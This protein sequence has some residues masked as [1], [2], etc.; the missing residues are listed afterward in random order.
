MYTFVRALAVEH[1][2][3]KRWL[4]V[5]IAAEPTSTLFNKYRKIYTV[6][7]NTNITEEL[8]LDLDKIMAALQA[9]T[10]TISDYLVQNGNKTLPTEVGV[11]SIIR[12]NAIYSDAFQADYFVDTIDYTVGEGVEVPRE[13]RNDLVVMPANE[14]DRVGYDYVGLRSRVL[15]NVNGFYHRTAANS[16]GY[17]VVDGAKS[18]RRS[19]KNFLGLLSFGTIGELGLHSITDSM[20]SFEKDATTGIVEKVHIK[21]PTGAEGMTPLLIL[22][23]YML[24]VDEQNCFMTSPGILTFKTYKYPFMERYIESRPY[25]DFSGF[26]V[27]HIPSNEY[28]V[29]SAKLRSEAYLR[30][31]FKM[32]Q[33]FLAMVPTDRLVVEKSYPDKENIPHTYLSYEEPKWPL[34]TGEGK[35]EVYW[36]VNDAG[37][38]ILR[39]Y[40]TYRYHRNFQTTAEKDR[41]AIDDQAWMGHPGHFG[42][43]WFLKLFTED[44]EVKIQ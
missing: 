10:G 30:G 26:D 35:H 39:G 6:L 3:N 24:M 16:K 7:T 44:I 14:G 28:W 43:A 18:A 9:N 15:A 31:Y 27:S 41:V 13:K 29:E 5:D 2:I 25:L 32:N 17:Y 22:G 40:D 37:V 4:Q 1:G 34:V 8:T 42:A 21:L 11:P 20:L 33:S 12:N 19:G 23:G 38:W 36:S